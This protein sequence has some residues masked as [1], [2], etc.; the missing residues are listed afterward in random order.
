MYMKKIFYLC[1]FSIIFQ[2]ASAQQTVPTIG[3]GTKLN[4]RFFL[5]GQSLSINLIVK[6]MVDTVK[7]DWNIR[8]FAYGSYLISAKAFQKGKKINFI[9]PVPQKVI[10]LADDETF[11]IISKAA[12]TDLMKEKRFVYNNTT[13]VLK[14]DMKENPFKLGSQNL[15][16]IHVVRS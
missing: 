4:Y 16:L 6:S 15:D 2:Q 9:Q 13:Y 11:A 12:F 5:Y 10:I 1:L 8:G 3:V 7:L 14:D